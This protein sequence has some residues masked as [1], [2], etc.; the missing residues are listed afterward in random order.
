MIEVPRLTF[1]P[2]QPANLAEVLEAQIR[3]LIECGVPGE[4]GV[5]EA[6]FKDDAMKLAGEFVYS[7]ELAGIGL[8]RVCIVHYGVRE[9]F[10]A[11]AGSIT[12]WNDPDKFTLFDGVTTPDGLWVVQ[13]QFGPKYKN[14]KPCDIRAEHDQ[15]EQL[16][17]PKE[18]LTAFLYWSKELLRESYMDFPGAVSGYGYVPSLSLFGG[19]PELDDYNSDDDAASSFGSVSVSRGG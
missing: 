18:G 2:A 5:D 19:G 17:V 10:L 6:K 9:R 11:E 12:L 15:L 7:T 13:G 8:D 3:R 1:V 4:V 16:G 14:R